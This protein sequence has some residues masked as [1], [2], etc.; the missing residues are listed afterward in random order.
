MITSC[1]QAP[2]NCCS[3]YT[4]P[5]KLTNQLK[6]AVV[7]SSRAAG[8]REFK[9]D[10]GTQEQPIRK[11]FGS[12]SQCFWDRSSLWGAPPTASVH[13]NRWSASPVVAWQRDIGEGVVSAKY[14]RVASVVRFW[15]GLPPGGGGADLGAA[16][17]HIH[18]RIVRF[19]FSSPRSSWFTNQ[20]YRCTE[21]HS[22]R[23][24]LS[25]VGISEIYLH[26]LF[27]FA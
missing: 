10:L 2:N 13:T 7:S 9:S 27:V 15:S 3:W 22:H 14:E 24:S 1:R 17:R 12:N 18:T 21:F 11:R 20:K 26:Y 23:T 5:E 4:A 19:F 8:Q 25:Y 6:A 16:T